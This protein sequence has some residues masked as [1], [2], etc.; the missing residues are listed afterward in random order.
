MTAI[1]KELLQ[2]SEQMPEL[3]SDLVCKVNAD[4]SKSRS[5]AENVAVKHQMAHEL[6][7]MGISPEGVARVLHLEYKKNA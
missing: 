7:A 1:K 5:E 2:V 4:I 6:A 3:L